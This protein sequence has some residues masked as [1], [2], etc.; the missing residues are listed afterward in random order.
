MVI[1]TM[2]NTGYKKVIRTFI[3]DTSGNTIPLVMMVA[4][5]VMII[6][7]AVA[8]SA[9]QLFTIARGEAHSQ[10]AYFAAESAL[11]RSLCNLDSVITKESYAKSRGI[12]YSGEISF[13]NAIIDS[14]ND[15]MNTAVYKYF[16]NIGVYGNDGMDKAQATLN[17]SWEGGYSKVGLKK[18]EFP[19]TI[20]AT[21]QMENGIFKSY[22]KKA[23]AR[24]NFSVWISD[25]FRLNGAAYTLGDLLANGTE[26]KTSTIEGDVYVFGTGLDK[27]KRMEQYYNGGICAAGN[28]VLHIQN[29]SAFTRNLVRAGTFDDNDG[30]NTC[31]IVVDKD[32]V[33]QGIQVFGSNDSIVAIRDAYTF[34]DV[35]L[36][37]SNSFIAINGN[38]F[39]LNGG[40][41]KRHDTSS[42]VLNLAPRY[43]GGMDNSYMKSRIVINGHV[44]VNGATFRIKDPVTGEAGHKM[45]GVSLAW[46]GYQPVYI[47]QGIGP[48][49]EYY[50]DYVNALIGSNG[51]SVILQKEWDNDNFNFSGGDTW[52]NWGNWITEICGKAGYLT[53][54]ITSFPG[55]IT[56]FCNLGMAAN[57]GIY[58]IDSL[59]E[60]LSDIK[61]PGSITCNIAG[62]IEG[63]ESSFFDD[64]IDLEWDFYT[65]SSG[66]GQAL[67]RLMGLLEDHVQV[68]AGKGFNDNPDIDDIM[69]SFTPGLDEKTEFMTISDHLESEIT[70]DPLTNHVLRYE[71][72]SDPDTVDVIADL[73]AAYEESETPYTDYYFLILNFNPDKELRINGQVNGIVF[74]LG[75]VV[76]EGDGV[77][78]GAVIAAG[79]G[80]DPSVAN[81]VRGSAAEYNSDGSPRLPRVFIEDGSNNINTFK[82]WEYA[83]LVF[84]NGGSI[85]FPGRDEL[86]SIIEGQD[87]FNYILFDIF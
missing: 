3:F 9:V 65:G 56:G 85:V 71:A 45:E 17:F 35:E 6:G 62:D 75:K 31:A 23:V 49:A 4:L 83:A 11:E 12:V 60:D 74:S 32:I 26:D 39:G 73:E 41:G 51:F 53:N 82:S 25:R 20:T 1:K 52:E 38:F 68:F 66:M 63:L 19:I 42:A 77:V 33:A 43:G 50:D 58:L 15:E 54:S 10:L 86:L 14:L 46:E 70:G 13:I 16:D 40:D 47:A 64:C 72:T 78:N 21:A 30:S 69:Y 2:R 37:G 18:L 44:L 48:D 7:G 8:Y 59:D 67:D 28:A 80:F 61:K 84:E 76:I 55:T 57:N 29:G 34:D 22:G 36:S 79:R 5:V 24:R 87:N 81:Y 27:A